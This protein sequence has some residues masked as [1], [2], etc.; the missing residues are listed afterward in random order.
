MT[1]FNLTEIEKKAYRSTFQ[2]GL[3]DIFLGSQL[4]ILSISALLSNMGLTNKLHMGL[5]ILLQV[6]VVLAFTIGKKR[7]TIPRMG[8]VKFGTKRKR[9]ITKSRIILLISVIAG[10]VVFLIA[11]AF[12]QS[13]PA[14]QSKLLLL[15]PVAWVI[16]SVIIFSLLAYYMDFTRL[17]LYG[18]LFALP[19]PVDMAI[20]QF[21]NLNLNH[22]AFAVPGI[23]MLI[24]GTVLLVRFL[25]DYPISGQEV[26]NGQP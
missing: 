4:L 14:G 12:I 20:K 3:W 21:T 6:L 17:Y 15:A 13:N 9:K 24:V 5:L 8:Y 2:D 19:V 1:I 7:I 18:V 23:A 10:V 25:R 22:V 11:S 26:L 16:N